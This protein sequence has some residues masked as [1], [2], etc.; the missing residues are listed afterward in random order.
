MR[1]H[2]KTCSIPIP[3][4]PTALYNLPDFPEETIEHLV[5]EC[6]DPDLCHV[7]TKWRLMLRPQPNN[8]EDKVLHNLMVL[9][10]VAEAL[11][12]LSQS[13]ANTGTSHPP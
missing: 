2:R 3:P 10:F 4:A 6:D 12:L 5:M 8:D 1:R 7:R 9:E 11:S 13:V